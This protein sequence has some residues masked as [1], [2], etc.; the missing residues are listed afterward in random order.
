MIIFN[1]FQNFYKHEQ[2]TYS[3]GTYLLTR[4]RLYTSAKY[5]EGLYVCY[6]DYTPFLLNKGHL[7]KKGIHIYL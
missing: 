3:C 5:E 1:P 6:I 4:D 7:R 2:V